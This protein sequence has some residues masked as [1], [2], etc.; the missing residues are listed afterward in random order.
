MLRESRGTTA[1]L[2]GSH[3]EWQMGFTLCA[4]SG[5]YLVVAW[6]TIL[7]GI[8]RRHPDPAEK[9]KQNMAILD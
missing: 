6:K 8:L 1:L 2:G 3:S 9:H 5:K 4:N 7:K